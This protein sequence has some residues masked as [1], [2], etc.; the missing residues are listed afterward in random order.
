MAVEKRMASRLRRQVEHYESKLSSATDECYEIA[1]RIKELGLDHSPEVEIPR[2][3]DL[4]GRTEKLLVEYLDGLAVAQD[5]R[6]MLASTDNDRET[7]AIR[8][9]LSVVKQLVEQGK[10]RVTCADV[11]LRVGLAILTE[12]VLVAPLEGIAKVDVLNNVDGSEFLSVYFAGPIR[13]AG[14]TG[15]ALAVLIADMI[16]RELGIDRYVPTTP[17]VER[18]KEEFGLYRVG[19]Q[20]RPTP[21]E[22][23]KIVRACPVMI[24][25]ESTEK[26][27]CSGYG[28]VRN[29]DGARVRGGVLLVIGEGLCLKAPK[30]VK[31]TERLNVPGWEFI[32]EFTSRGR[33]DD[34]GSEYWIDEG[35]FFLKCDLDETFNEQ[36]LRLGG[37]WN[38]AKQ[39]WE[40]QP[41]EQDN[42]L[43]V[44]ERVYGS[45]PRPRSR[46]VEKVWKFM[47]DIIAGR[48]VI[49]DPGEPGGFRLRY[50]RCRTSGLAAG[51]LNPVSMYA[52]DDF[53]TVGTQMKIER[54]GKATAVTPCDQVEGPWLLLDDG[55]FL[56]VDEMETW[57]SL[58]DS[59]SIIWDCGEL[60][61]GYGEFLENNRTLVPAGYGMDWWA[62][63]VCRSVDDEARLSDL[64]EVLGLTLEELPAGLPCSDDEVG[65]RA[66]LSLLRNARLDWV[67]AERASEEFGTSLPPPFNLWWKDLPLEWIPALVSELSTATVEVAGGS[68]VLRFPDAA[69]GWSAELIP[70]PGEHIEGRIPP[71]PPHE[72]PVISPDYSVREN[73]HLQVHGLVKSCLMHLGLAHEHE[74]ED[75]LVCSGFEALLDGLGF[76]VDLPDSDSLPTRQL[77]DASAHAQE[78]IERIRR[79]LSVVAEEEA[80]CDSLEAVRSRFRISAETKARQAGMS[81]AET[82]SVGR[83]AAEEVPDEGPDDAFALAHCENLLEE[84]EIDGCLWLVRRCSRLRIE[85][86]AGTRIGGRMGRPEKAAPREMK[87][88]PHA[89]FPVAVSGGPQRLLNVAAAKGTLRVQLGTRFCSRCANPSPF[90]RCEHRDEAGGICGARTEAREM[91][92]RPGRS[93]ASVQSIDLS[94]MLE[95]ARTRLGLDRIPAKIKGVKGL[96]SKHRIPESIEKGVLRAHHGLPVFR[97]GTIRYDMSDVPLTHFTPEEINTPW[98]KLEQLGYTHD[99][100]GERLTSDEQV[101]ELYPQDFV[102]SKGGAEFMARVS[103]FIDD[104]LVRHYGSQ[105][106]YRIEDASGV[107]GQMIIALAPH[108]SGGVLGRLIGWSD[109]SGGYAHPLFHAAKRRN[110]DGDEDCVMLLMDGLLNF[111]RDLLPANRGGLMDAPLVLTTRLNPYEIDKE[112]LNVDGA[113]SYDSRFYEAA[114][115]QLHPKELEDRMGT[116]GMR[117]ESGQHAAM[118]GIGYTHGTKR[119]DSGPALSAYKTLG[120]MR[121]KMNGQLAL[122]H[123]L[124]G[125]DECRVASSVVRSHFLPDLRGNLLAFTRQQVRCTKCSRSYRRM[126]LAGKCIEPVSVHGSGLRDF[127]AAPSEAR[128]CGGGLA[129]TVSQGAVRKYIAVMEY[130]IEKYGVDLYTRQ[131]V[132]WLSDSTDSLFSND[133]SKQLSISD[134]F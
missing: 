35:R 58:S 106:Y 121:D 62:A 48:P 52:L 111:S 65:S 15:Q 36:A 56:R 46:R 18:I 98:R 116:L 49:G 95:R 20:Y 86:G 13:A 16:R 77:V 23:E 109:T 37:F 32:T 57:N 11:A 24:N 122:G 47:N 33:T 94:G 68:H 81:I 82:D 9:S 99:I 90:L 29:I 117:L 133:H 63:D 31:H 3:E 128:L 59:V 40:F 8:I 92:R 69:R 115:K 4:A 88:P 27:E 123:K 110:C 50:G 134:F 125:V 21:E 126:P 12:A 43:T 114:R 76:A 96:I 93:P 102:L 14:G 87:P 85:D 75:I 26:Q 79:S 113:W 45:E 17:E 55:R 1:A 103:R 41:S 25:G 104:L 124:R 127:G 100:D 6:E 54:P 66:W 19:L 39:A 61:L 74:R 112:A 5:I 22:T 89:L 83:L 67:A 72:P 105:P 78:R 73:I 44:A 71:G 129:L 30:L 53:F 97:D 10:D 84:H 70:G 7:T 34:G 118:R 119:L 132:T 120:T 38:E 2:A 51:A 108:T 107:V 64:G 60:L 42:V 131:N 28:R 130:V 80:R 91:R 101:L